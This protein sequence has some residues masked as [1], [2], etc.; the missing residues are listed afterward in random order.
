M[1]SIREIREFTGLSHKQLAD[2]LGVSKSLVWYAETGG[3]NLPEAAL[4]KLNAL[5]LLLQG[6]KA[7]STTPVA[8][9]MRL[10]SNPDLLAERT[11]R[12]RLFTGAAPRPC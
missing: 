3:R 9:G 4:L 10:V 8:P 1:S 11:G 7:G 12:K 2:W 6:L 5:V